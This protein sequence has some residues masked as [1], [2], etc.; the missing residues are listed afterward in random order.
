VRAELLDE[1]HGEGG[2]AFERAVDSH[3]KNLRRRLGRAAGRLRSVYG[4][5]YRLDVETPRPV[6]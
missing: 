5:G 2:A 4:I 3:V 6:H 1:F